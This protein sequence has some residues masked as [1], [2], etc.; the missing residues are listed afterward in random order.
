MQEFSRAWNAND[1]IVNNLSNAGFSAIVGF[2]YPDEQTPR[3]VIQVHNGKV[4]F[5]GNYSDEKLDWD[6]R[7]DIEDWRTWLT[8]GFGIAR[9][10]VSVASG[11]LK[12]L[13]G[14]YRSMIRNPKLASP[15]L[16]HF[17]LMGGIKTDFDK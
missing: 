17:E 14:D 6:M 13:K 7:A 1:E 11:K 2:G 5:A 8:E 12:F 15:F 10:G 16:K 3:G 4:S 9:L